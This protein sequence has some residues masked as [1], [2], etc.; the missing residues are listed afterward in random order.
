MFF[1]FLLALEL[2]QLQIV[3][4]KSEDAKGAHEHPE[5]ERAFIL[6]LRQ[7]WFTIRRFGNYW[8]NLN[9][10][11]DAPEPISEMYLGMLL[12]Q[13][14]IDG[15]SVFVVRGEFSQCSADEFA[16]ILGSAEESGHSF[17]SGNQED[18]DLKW[19]IQASLQDSTASEEKRKAP[20]EP[21]IKTPP[22]PAPESIESI[23]DLR[24]K[25][26]KKFQTE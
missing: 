12:K 13:F 3:P 14:E 22:V 10:T 24:Q 7:H 15:Y 5:Q 17:E 16:A 9:S 2:F 18:E 4:I 6:N 23:E 26:L 20:E 8:Y 1:S 21:E 19:A 11:L 25:R